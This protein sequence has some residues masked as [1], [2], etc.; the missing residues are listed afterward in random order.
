MDLT[1]KLLDFACVFRA[2]ADPVII[3]VVGSE[4]VFI[5]EMKLRV[6]L[7]AQSYQRAA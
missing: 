3:G 2:N 6:Y 5:S 7:L 4:I 1:R